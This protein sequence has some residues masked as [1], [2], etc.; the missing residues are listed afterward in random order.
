MKISRTFLLFGILIF[1]NVTFCSK[2]KNPVLSSEPNVPGK[3]HIY[4]QNYVNTMWIGTNSDSLGTEMKNLIGAKK[5]YWIGG[6]VIV[7][8]SCQHG[9]YFNPNTIVICEISVEGMQTTIEQIAGDPH[10]YAH[11]GWSNGL[12]EH[13]WYVLASFLDY[14][15]SG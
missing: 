14:R 5:K 6:E 1:L 7:D 4:I 2:S 9:F 8:S 10:Y 3:H 13:A 15:S 11:N 12:A